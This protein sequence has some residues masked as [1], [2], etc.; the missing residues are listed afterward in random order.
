MSRRRPEF[1]T[2]DLA[3]WPTIAWTELDATG[4]SRLQKHIDAIERYAKDET[5]GSIE[6][7][8]GVNRKQLYRFLDRALSLHADGR[9][10]GFRALVVHARVTEYTR[11]LP[12]TKCGERGGA[13]VRF[14]YC[15][16]V[17]PGSLRGSCCRSDSAA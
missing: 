2:L 11:L 1:Q 7:V 14:R 17:I 3:S 15:L 12:V 10:Y 5:I 8:T 16:S 13:V 6:A 4:R 9:I